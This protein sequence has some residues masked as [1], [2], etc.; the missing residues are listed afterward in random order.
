MIDNFLYSIF[1]DLASA[2]CNLYSK[3]RG[4]V[5]TPAPPLVLQ[6]KGARDCSLAP[7]P[8]DCFAGGVRFCLT[9]SFLPSSSQEKYFVTRKASPALTSCPQSSLNPFFAV[10]RL[11][12]AIVHHLLSKRPTT[13]N[14]PRQHL[15]CLLGLHMLQPHEV[16][17]SDVRRNLRGQPATSALRSNGRGCPQSLTVWYTG[18]SASKQMRSCTCV[19]WKRGA[20]WGI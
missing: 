14:V 17:D 12:C 9:N 7:L 6:K 11:T 5:G 8:Y 13:F 4:W 18:E 19:V 16:K 10:K 1:L 3:S 20:G 15:F 2:R